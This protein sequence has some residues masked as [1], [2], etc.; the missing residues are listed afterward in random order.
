MSQLN[1]LHRVQLN[2]GSIPLSFS[3]S[4][5]SADTTTGFSIGTQRVGATAEFIGGDASN[6]SR[7]EITATSRNCL[8]LIR[9]DNAASTA[10]ADQLLV[11]LDS[12]VGSPLFNVVIKPQFVNLISIED[13]VKIKVKSGGNNVD[14]TFAVVQIDAE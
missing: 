5:L 1:V 14:Y 10:D 2:V 12:T 3:H 11:C 8:M 13:F 9:N 6:F 4:A 7:A